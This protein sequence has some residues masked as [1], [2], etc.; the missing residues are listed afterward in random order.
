[1]IEIPGVASGAEVARSIAERSGGRCLVAFSC[2]KD[3]L[4]AYLQ[5]RDVFAEVAL[6][7]LDLVPGLEFVDESIAYFERALGV[8][9]QR[10][11]HPSLWRW[12]NN[13]TY[14][15]PERC[16]VIEAANLPNY[17]YE[18]TRELIAHRLGWGG[19]AWT[20]DGVRAADSPMRRVALATHGPVSERQRTFKPVWDWQKADVLNAIKT[21]GLQLPVDYE[22]FGRSFD[23]ID[24][25]FLDPIRK[26]FPR[27][28]A[29]ILEWFPLAD[30]QYLREEMRDAR[31]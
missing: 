6:Y 5:V 17:N 10:A 26:R 24:L 31:A 29:R 25:R 12:L 20:A 13:F 23:G 16:A 1:M 19:L 11:P 3:A 8:T 14:Q 9:I 21:A 2:G 7:H 4:A 30:V 15:S 28:Y 27:D 18:Q 22:L